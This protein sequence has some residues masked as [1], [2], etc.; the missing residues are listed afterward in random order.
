MKQR[1]N[2]KKLL[3]IGLVGGVASGK[4]TIARAFADRGAR[5]IDAD[6]LTH[7]ELD[8]VRVIKQIVAAF[9]KVVASNGR[10][11]R[12]RLAEAAFKSSE[13]LDAL[14]KIV[15]PPVLTAIERDLGRLDS[16]KRP[17]AVVIEAALLIETE[18]DK[19]C[20]HVIYVACPLKSR[21]WR[22]KQGRHWGREDLK[23]RERF[24]LMLGAKRAASTDVINNN[25]SPAYA[26]KAVGAFWEEHVLPSFKKTGTSRI[27][28]KKTV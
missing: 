21:L 19:I 18:L 2:Y 13:N 22:A 5:I 1:N 16:R 14:T 26:D 28:R 9:G 6:A 11:D 3:I 12:G 7:R 24:Q 15:H 23:R 8:K 20:D 4:S 27:K 17:G 25:L 10:I